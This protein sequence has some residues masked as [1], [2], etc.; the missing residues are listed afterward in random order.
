M[1]YLRV[2][3]LLLVQARQEDLRQIVQLA[4]QLV[5]RLSLLWLVLFVNLDQTRY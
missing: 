5:D 3:I 1:G 2:S 4:Q